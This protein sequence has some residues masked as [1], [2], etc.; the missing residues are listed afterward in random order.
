[1]N[2][3][4]YKARQLEH[5]ERLAEQSREQMR[6]PTFRQQ[7]RMTLLAS[8]TVL[9]GLFGAICF[10]AAS[11]ATKTSGHLFWKK[12]TV[13]PTETRVGWL[14]A[15]IVLV[16]IAI[17]LAALSIR[18]VTRRAAL[19]KYPAILTGREV[20]KIQQIS[21]ITGQS[22]QRVYE[23][24]Q[25]MI[26]SGM[27]DDFFVDYQREQVVST[28][29]LPKTSHKTVVTCS[30][31]GGNNEVIVGITRNCSFCEQP[32]VLASKWAAEATSASTDEM[33]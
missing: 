23:D 28:K 7:Y 17:T 19:K 9:A 15:G 10:G 25:S 14:I 8:S 5:R 2:R 4:E 18:L 12:T 26:G 13:V 16:L 24:M 32:L 20:I 1:V 21:D 6:D 3:F 29:Y 31:C 33:T 30:G 27:I 11:E 22:V